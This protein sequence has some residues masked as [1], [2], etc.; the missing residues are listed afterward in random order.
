MR[1]DWLKIGLLAGVVMLGAGASSSQSVRQADRWQREA[2]LAR[3][4]GQWD[5]A[6][7]RYA[8]AAETFPGTP[9]G[10]A[11]AD[12]AARMKSWG[13]QPD[14]SPASED[15]ISWLTELFDLITWP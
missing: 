6:Y 8:A 11:G 12:R 2:D 3:S 5:I 15:P 13:L 7:D 14:R 4:T 9:H 10:K 1:S